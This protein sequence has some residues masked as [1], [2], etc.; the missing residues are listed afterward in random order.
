MLGWALFSTRHE[1]R[2][3][4]CAWQL[5]TE[6]ARKRRNCVRCRADRVPCS[7]SPM[8]KADKLAHH[9]A[10]IAH[11][12]ARKAAVTVALWALDFVAL[13]LALGFLAKAA[14]I[15]LANAFGPVIGAIAIAFI[16]MLFSVV[17]AAAAIDPVAPP[18][19]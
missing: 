14:C 13:C 4:N 5:S 17:I 18:G 2:G 6:S 15:S 19:S 12:K 9:A 16:A 11:N 10:D 8:T 3:P 7:G 1:K